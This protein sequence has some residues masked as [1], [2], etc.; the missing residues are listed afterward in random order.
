VEQ[1]LAEI[2]CQDGKPAGNGLNDHP[3]Q[4]DSRCLLE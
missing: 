2:Q 4:L 1:G 3:W